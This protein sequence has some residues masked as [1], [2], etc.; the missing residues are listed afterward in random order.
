MLACSRFSLLIAVALS[1]AACSESTTAKTVAQIDA[2]GG[3][4]VLTRGSAAGTR[5][6]VPAGAVDTVTTFGIEATDAADHLTAGMH[7]VG[8]MVT[9]TPEGVAFA[10]P[11][12]ITL[13]ARHEPMVLLTRPHG[14]TSWTRVDGAVWDAETGL[15][16]A[17]VMHFS[18]FVPVGRDPIVADA[19][20]GST[21]AGTVTV[22]AG[23]PIGRDAGIDCSNPRFS[24]YP[25]CTRGYECDLFEGGC[26]SGYANCYPPDETTTHGS[27]SS[28]GGAGLDAPCTFV[29]YD[30]TTECTASLRCNAT[31]PGTDGT[32]RPI[33]D[34]AHPCFDD[35]VSIVECRRPS[36]TAAFGFCEVVGHR[37]M[38]AESIELSCADG[39]DGDCDGLIDCADSDCRTNP[40]CIHS[41]CDPVAGTGCGAGEH[42]ALHAVDATVASPVVAEC[43]AN[44][45][46]IAGSTCTSG[47]DCGAGL[48][49][50]A[51]SGSSS[52]PGDA[53]HWYFTT[54][55]GY[56]VRGGGLC[57]ELCPDGD[58]TASTCGRGEI[59]HQILSVGAPSGYGA[60]Y[61]PRGV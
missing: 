9:L 49:C 51:I 35:G 21:D 17:E 11:V 48:S 28:A 6:D 45:A 30:H 27:C 15:V 43:F 10:I 38:P 58:W 32:C 24:G 57:V 12:Q 1:L 20:P 14:T 8:P 5:L 33:C 3:S 16:T 60:C 40:L 26:A 25:V 39:V 56:F 42:C 36:A 47:A 55:E 23:P 7:S 29:D 18:D 44:G 52:A 4:L 2:S 22:D 19:G 41:V 37:C 50:A 13:P 61:A 31:A 59:C 54:F 53:T 46:G 34:D